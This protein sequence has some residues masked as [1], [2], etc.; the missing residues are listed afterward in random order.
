MGKGDWRAR[1]I[2]GSIPR[3]PNFAK[4]ASLEFCVLP[5]AK[6]GELP[7]FRRGQSEPN[8]LFWSCVL[9]S[10]VPQDFG[11][12]ES[13]RRFHDLESW[14]FTSEIPQALLMIS[15]LEFKQSGYGAVWAQIFTRTYRRF[16]FLKF[17]RIH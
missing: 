10:E 12:L 7:E 13:I 17:G 16:S 1:E 9:G 11:S 5:Q 8:S 3:G 2:R 6:L 14:S 4:V 15:S